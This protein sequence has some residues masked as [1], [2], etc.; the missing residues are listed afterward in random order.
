MVTARSA[1]DDVDKELLTKS[2]IYRKY[3]DKITDLTNN[4][5]K[6]SYIDY[7]IKAQCTVQRFDSKYVIDGISIEGDLI[8]L[9]RHEY[10]KD[11]YDSIIFPTLVPRS[12]DLIKFLGQWYSIKQCTPATNEESGIIAWDFTAGQITTNEY[13]DEENGC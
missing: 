9:F 11:I 4:E 6:K 1:R 5:S 8:G 13:Q 10:T 12:K 7:E 2:I 3:N